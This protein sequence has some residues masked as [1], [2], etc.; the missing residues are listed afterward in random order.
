MKSKILKNIVATVTTAV[1][2]AT[3]YGIPLKEVCTFAEKAIAETNVTEAL[4][5]CGDFNADNQINVFDVMR[6]KRDI[7]NKTPQPAKIADINDDGAFNIH[8][9]MILQDYVLLRDV[10]IYK[11]LN[12]NGETG[13]LSN[14]Y[15]YSI[16]SGSNFDSDGITLIG[17]DIIVNSDI[18]SNGN[19]EM[20]GEYIIQPHR[21]VSANAN[22]SP[23]YM[24][25]KIVETYFSD[26]DTYDEF[27]VEQGDD[28]NY[29]IEKPIISYGDISIHK[30]LTLD[31][32]CM[33]AYN[34]I[35]I[36][37]N[38]INNGDTVLYS[39]Y[40]DITIDGDS[41][42]LVGLIYAPSGTVKLSAKNVQIDGII[43]AKRVIIE[44]AEMINI[45]GNP[46]LAEFIGV[47]SEEMSIPYSEWEYIKKDDDE[48]F[49]EIVKEQ[50][51][52]N[53]LSVD[54]EWL[55]INYGDEV[56]DAYNETMKKQLVETLYIGQS[57]G[58]S[59]YR[60]VIA[61]LEESLKNNYSDLVWLKTKLPD[62]V[63]PGGQLSV[64]IG[65]C[66]ISS[67]IVEND[68]FIGPRLL[69]GPYKWDFYINSE[70]NPEIKDSIPE[71]QKKK[72]KI[73]D[74]SSFTTLL[75]GG[76]TLFEGAKDAVVTGLTGIAA[77]IAQSICSVLEKTGT[78]KAVEKAKSKLFEKLSEIADT[79]LFKKVE[80]VTA[81]GFKID[82]GPLDFN[83]SVVN[84]K[85]NVETK[86][87]SSSVTLEKIKDIF[88]EDTLNYINDKSH[89]VF[90]EIYEKVE[91]VADISS[92]VIQN[93]VA[94]VECFKE[95]TD[96]FLIAYDKL[97][98]I[99]KAFDSVTFYN[100]HLNE[101]ASDSVKYSVKVTKSYATS[102]SNSEILREELY[103]QGVTY[104]KYSNC[105]HHVVPHNMD[106]AK[107]AREILEAFGID[108][109]SAA[110]GVLLP[111]HDDDYV[112]FESFHPGGH[113][114]QYC[115]NV[116]NRL[117]RV[118]DKNEG[119]SDDE[120]Q[121]ALCDE[122]TKIKIDL[123]NS[124]ITVND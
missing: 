11:K 49:P 110:N 106:A 19:I 33:M 115:Y 45:N 107:E 98:N 7:L 26:S 6:A 1:F 124:I 10:S 119:K 95:D 48:V 120:I 32:T 93:T 60:D 8:D 17:E 123:F 25:S 41:I 59:N 116:N 69:Y 58:V 83:I 117:Q 57:E 73:N 97:G 108:L 34:S 92:E 103:S 62:K 84:D 5:K 4:I 2:M 112:I 66:E 85:W 46:A 29:I 99:E 14:N 30:E 96:K 104:H 21:S 9:A 31:K 64:G 80:V 94:T 87:D 90:S 114:N 56:V 23:L 40:G 82:I 3:C 39:K 121:R 68:D 89:K 16:F 18:A 51:Y 28:V 71:N 74:L 35:T 75:A 77:S 24:D 76:A 88:D 12:Q 78:E 81:E 101:Y 67:E 50:I 91:N 118:I 47:D 111:S 37:N 54:D 42:N 27:T 61:V 105:A 65:N 22:V 113:T 36:D 122:L 55:R 102:K 13:E 44:A 72:F 79:D 38:T 15:K 70:D 86:V 20:T 63:V 53:P 109:N 43:I 52:N 100:T